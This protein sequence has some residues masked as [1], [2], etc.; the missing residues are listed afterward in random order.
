MHIKKLLSRYKNSGQLKDRL[1]INHLI[2][3]FNVFYHKAAI[4]ILFFKIDK[5]LHPIL[6]T[7]LVYLGRCPDTIENLYE[8]TYDLTKIEINPQLL[9]LLITNLDK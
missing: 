6:K 4:K 5:E 2:S 3:F 8:T 1:I 7:Y 9:K